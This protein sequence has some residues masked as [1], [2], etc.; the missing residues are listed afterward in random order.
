MARVGSFCRKAVKTAVTT[1]F[2]RLG[3]NRYL[4]GKNGK[5]FHQLVL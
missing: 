5:K 2:N 4:P 3:K 1:G